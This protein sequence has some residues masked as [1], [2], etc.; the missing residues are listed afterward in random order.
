LTRAGVDIF[1]EYK[2]LLD[3]NA[4]TDIVDALVHRKDHKPSKIP[5]RKAIK[6]MIDE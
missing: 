4:N 3:T 2:K 5:G 1:S 6:K